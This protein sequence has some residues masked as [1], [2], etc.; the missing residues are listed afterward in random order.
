MY[1]IFRSELKRA[2]SYWTNASGLYFEEVAKTS[3][4]DLVIE[5]VKNEHDD[6]YPFDGQGGDLAHAFFP[7]NGRI[8]FDMEEQFT[9]N[10]TNYNFRLIA[11]HEI[12]HALGLDH[13]FELGSL[14]YPYYSGYV[15][16]N[17][18]A[19]VDIDAIKSLYGMLYIK[20]FN[21]K[22]YESHF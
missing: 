21:M 20:K 16:G 7:Q 17:P 2:F 9:L 15:E 3:P 11:T 12:G 5:F 19:S 22:N 1:F 18:L 14:M 8:H 13:I 6:G 10:S 4:A